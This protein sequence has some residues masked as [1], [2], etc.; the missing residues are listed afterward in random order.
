MR[1][2]PGGST[3]PY[4]YKGGELHCLHF[5]SFFADEP[6]LLARIAAER[7]FVLR[8]VERMPV[9][10]DLYETELT[11]RV[12]A[13]LAAMIHA[14]GERI[15]KLAIVGCPASG[16]R[17]LSRAFEKEGVETGPPLRYFD[18]P[19]AAKSWLVGKEP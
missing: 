15:T 13:G 17:R 1:K 5:G 12:H 7:E 4:Y 19:E 10:M 8:N 2:S 6:S 11:G 14:T 9:W 16:R 18:D 3:F